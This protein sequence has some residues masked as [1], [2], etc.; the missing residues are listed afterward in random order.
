M[1]KRKCTGKQ[2]QIAAEILKEIRARLGFLLEVGL[3]I[4]LPEQRCKN[5]FRR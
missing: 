4:S 2:K 5:T 1:L 3:G